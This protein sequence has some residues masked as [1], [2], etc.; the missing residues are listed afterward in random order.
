MLKVILLLDCDDC[1][2]SHHHAIVRSA[3][4]LDNLPAA[5]NDIMNDAYHQDWCLNDR[6]SICAECFDAK[7]QKSGRRV[8]R[9]ER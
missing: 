5:V 2:Q 1:G 8:E 9:E 4:Q 6:S 7:W 3:K